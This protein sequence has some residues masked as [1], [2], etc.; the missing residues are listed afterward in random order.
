MTLERKSFFLSSPKTKDSP[1]KNHFIG[2]NRGRHSYIGNRN[3]S[4]LSR[5]FTPI[6][7]G[8]QTINVDNGDFAFVEISK[9][10]EYAA[11]VRDKS[12]KP[13]VPLFFGGTRTCSG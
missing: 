1:I 2:K 12:E 9:S 11:R 6:Y 7:K 4:N 13:T 10:V 3:N 8:N 5:Y